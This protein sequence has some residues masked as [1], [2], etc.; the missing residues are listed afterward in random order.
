[1]H[2]HPVTHYKVVKKHLI[3][4]ES[5][6]EKLVEIYKEIV[7]NSNALTRARKRAN[8]L[9]RANNFVRFENSNKVL[10]TL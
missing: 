1:V 10:L 9:A 7:N 3:N 4:K 8:I 6:T 2:R 5:K